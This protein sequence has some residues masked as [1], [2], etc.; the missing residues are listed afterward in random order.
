MQCK[1]RGRPCTFS[2]DGLLDPD[3]EPQEESGIP[4]TGGSQTD[5]L[6]LAEDESVLFADSNEY[7][8]NRSKRRA[9]LHE[10]RVSKVLAS[11][12]DDI[13]KLNLNDNSPKCNS[14]GLDVDPFG[15]FIQWMPE[16]PLP[17]KYTG[18][19]EMPSRDIQMN[20]ISI[21]FDDR[22]EITP[23][24]PKRYFYDQL[25]KKGPLITPLLLNSIYMHTCK[26]TDLPDVPKTDVFFHRAKRLL[27]DF[28][29]VPRVSTVVA[30]MLMSQYEPSPNMYRGGAQQ[31]RSWMYSG[32]A[33]RMCLELGL[34]TENNISKDLNRDEIETR[35]RV[36]WS[37]YCLDKFQSS[38]WERPWMIPAT[39]ASTELPNVLPE[40]DLKE[41]GIVEGLRAKLELTLTSEEGLSLRA[42]AAL[43]GIADK[44]AFFTRVR[45]FH[46]KLLAWLRGLPT[47]LQWSLESVSDMNEVT[48]LPHP[49]PMLCHLHLIYNVLV[50]DVLLHLPGDAENLFQ[51]R[52]R[53]TH[54]TQLVYHMCIRPSTIIKFDYAVHSI[55]TAI[56]VH[57][58]HVYE[59][60][61]TVSQQ[62]SRFYDQS[63]TA[64]REIRKYA[65]IPNG[66]K[67]LQHAPNLQTHDFV[68]DSQLR[69]D[70]AYNVRHADT[71]GY[72]GEDTSMKPQDL[73]NPLTAANMH[74]AFVETDKQQHDLIDGRSNIHGEQRQC[75]NPYIVYPGHSVPVCKTAV[76]NAWAPSMMHRDVSNISYASSSP[77]DTVTSGVSPGTQA[78][79]EQHYFSAKVAES[80]AYTNAPPL[81]TPASLNGQSEFS[82]II[83][84]SH[85]SML[86][87]LDSHRPHAHVDISVGG[88][89]TTFSHSTSAS[90]EL[91][92][93]H[94][95]MHGPA[96]ELQQQQQQQ[97]HQQPTI[98]GPNRFCQQQ[99]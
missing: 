47:S 80:P 50:L 44:E 39:I 32:M 58:K 97:Q 94:Q 9:L 79:K 45:V 52:V 6:D 83:L 54:I 36:F 16:P 68:N 53:A 64:L 35:R 60:N 90:M 57:A 14:S 40:D 27:E 7:Q 17:T 76:P 41:R 26:F 37:C 86:H 8:L 24:I 78:F 28:L 4:E 74:S 63:I 29:D 59:Q 1:A 61:I 33:F 71:S 34:N 69:S 85:A 25:D 62:S 51:R 65:I 12:G 30:L 19:V 10:S 70:C 81:T 99:D 31:C 38:G 73:M 82:D 75:G 72:M 46:D 15:N 88:S 84:S 48:C 91:G 11:F 5:T 95:N 13:R 23:M 92:V 18:S 98:Y 93:F 49:R 2:K 67:I 21:F 3:Q 66:D 55:I 22:Y 77:A 96:M 87:S 56:K 43:H 20:L 89:L 42:F